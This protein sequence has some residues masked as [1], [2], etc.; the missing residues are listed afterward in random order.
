MAYS[1]GTTSKTRLLGIHPA[2]VA[3]ASAAIS[4]STQDF[5]VM[6]GLRL[7][8]QQKINVAR[9]VSKTMDS[10]HIVQPDGFGHALDL[11]PVLGGLPKWEWPL[12]YPIALAMRRAAVKQG[13]TIR[14]GG[15]WDRALNDLPDDPQG[16]KNAVTAYCFR[17]SGPDFLDGPHY[18]LK[19]F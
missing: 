18:E 8:E 10:K 7:V 15:V 1:F 4:E 2:L 5:M 11:V 3:V 12:I 16:M 14:W 6:E 19:L 13:T 17:H 9:G